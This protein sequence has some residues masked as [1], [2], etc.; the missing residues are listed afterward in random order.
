MVNYISVIIFFPTVVV[1]YHIKFEKFKWPCIAFC[2]RKIRETCKCCNKD[3]AVKDITPTHGFRE[4]NECDAVK[5]AKFKDHE[6]ALFQ[7][8]GP[9]SLNQSENE[10]RGSAHVSI[11]ENRKSFTTNISIN[12]PT[13]FK[14][15]EVIKAANSNGFVNVAFDSGE[16]DSAF[17]KPDQSS[18]E[19]N[20]KNS[21]ERIS[22]K[23][24]KDKSFMVL[25]FRNRFSVFV[26]HKI[27]RWVILAVMAGVLIFFAVQAYSRLC[28]NVSREYFARYR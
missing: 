24:R 28:K 1:M 16:N 9:D 7:R 6:S 17:T 19:L 5:N 18:N 21:K 12:N 3:A 8:V 14:Q 15:D 26:T 22:P 23:K 11:H 13:P 25:F 4:R 10:T 20:D 2:K 27:I